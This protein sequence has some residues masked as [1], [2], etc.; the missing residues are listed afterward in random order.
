MLLRRI[1]THLCENRPK[2]LL[3]HI[4]RVGQLHHTKHVRQQQE[5]TLSMFL[6]SFRRREEHSRNHPGAIRR[7]RTARVN[8]Q[9]V[10]TGRNERE[11]LGLWIVVEAVIVFVQRI[12][13]K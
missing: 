9:L 13:V 12:T 7:Q 5:T 10:D 2:S 11:T 3:Q 8:E 1:W 6:A 4:H